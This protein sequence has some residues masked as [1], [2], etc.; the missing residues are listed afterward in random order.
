MN[1]QERLTVNAA[2]VA[3]ATD[4]QC[5][6][7]SSTTTS[8]VSS[9]P[10][11]TMARLSP[12]RIMSMPAW[13]A[14]WAL[15]KSCAVMTVMGSRLRCMVRIVPS[16]T[17]LRWL[18]GGVPMGECELCRTCM[19]DGCG[20]DATP[21]T[22]AE[23][24]GTIRDRGPVMV[25][26]DA[27]VAADQADACWS[28]VPRARPDEAH[29][30]ATTTDRVNDMTRMMAL[31]TNNQASSGYIQ[32]AWYKGALRAT[33]CVPKCLR[34]SPPKQQFNTEPS[35]K[36]TGKK[37]KN[38]EF[39]QVDERCRAIPKSDKMGWWPTRAFL[40]PGPQRHDGF[41]DVELR[42]TEFPWSLNYPC[43]SVVFWITK[44]HSAGTLFLL[45]RRRG[46]GL[47][48]WGKTL[49][50]GD[51]LGKK[52]LLLLGVRL[53]ARLEDTFLHQLLGRVMEYLL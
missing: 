21:A 2:F 1:G 17:F 6:N 3:L 7:I 36:N 51:W 9:I 34:Q 25:V 14:T 31:C 43:L 5:S 22:D 49:G 26:K 40:F 33:L 23:V 45:V 12:T 20:G 11:A 32:M 27:A 30:L 13:S 15:G 50:R 24:A 41:Y 18:A 35:P 48:G 39:S 53:E 19:A 46:R 52:G 29:D 47:V 37:L 44:S 42:L 4:R 10:N 16:V 28:R 8:L 38:I